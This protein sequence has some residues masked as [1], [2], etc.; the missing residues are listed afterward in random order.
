M[1]RRSK[2]GDEEY[3]EGDEEYK[4]GDEEYKEGDEEYKEWSIVLFCFS[5][6]TNPN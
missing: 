1:T 3:K 2:E 5:Y 6:S 4:E